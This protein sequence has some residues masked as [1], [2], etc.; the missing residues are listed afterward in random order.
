MKT[1]D[2]GR[3]LIK[4]W[5]SLRLEA[6]LCPAGVPTIGYGH[7]GDVKLGDKI[8]AHQADAILD[9]DL[10]KFERGVE[11][12]CPGVNENQFAALVSFAFN[13]GLNALAISGLRTHLLAGRLD[14]ASKEFK[15]WCHA[16]VNGKLVALPGLVKRRADEEALFLSPVVAR[17]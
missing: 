10:D 12:L 13:L 14:A 16:K 7:T 9:L 17:A 1:N 6:Y 8:T 11:K 15:K 2:T 3:N 4:R 5:E